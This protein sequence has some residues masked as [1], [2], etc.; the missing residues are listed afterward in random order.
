MGAS[1]MMGCNK[2]YYSKTD[3][4]F[5]FKRT[6]PKCKGMMDSANF[7]GVGFD[8]RGYYSSESRKKSVIQRSCSKMK[9][10]QTKLIPDNM[11]IFGI[12]DYSIRTES[13]Q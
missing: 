3:P 2:G 7:L 11:N 4:C 12:Y 13:F 6:L 1:L 5:K 10:Y 8:G 9:R